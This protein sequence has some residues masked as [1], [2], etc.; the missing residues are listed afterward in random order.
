M[1]LIITLMCLLLGYPLSYY[2]A[3]ASPK[4]VNM[5]MIVCHE[6]FLWNQDLMKP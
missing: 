2:L 1:A 5:L 3:N 6:H 4:K